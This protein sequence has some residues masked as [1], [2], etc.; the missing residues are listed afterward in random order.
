MPIIQAHCM[1]G[2][3]GDRPVEV[4]D[5]VGRHGEGAQVRAAP[6]RKSGER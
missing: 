3:V 4:L 1:V 2:A 6:R 5:L